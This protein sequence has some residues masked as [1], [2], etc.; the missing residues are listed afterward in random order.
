MEKTIQILQ[1]IEI[2]WHF[3]DFKKNLIFFYHLLTK[4]FI[5]YYNKKNLR[6]LVND[7]KKPVE[8]CCI[9]RAKRA[10]FFVDL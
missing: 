7:L 3:N 1:K 6:T 9:R 5:R 2:F 4:N 10:V 8:R